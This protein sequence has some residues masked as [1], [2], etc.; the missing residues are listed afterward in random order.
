[1]KKLFL[2]FV[3]ILLSCNYK[4]E[5]LI[6]QNETLNIIK[7]LIEE[8]GLQMVK[9]YPNK[10]ELPICLNLK[11]IIVNNKC[12]VETKQ[13]EKVIVV[14][15]PKI[16]FTNNG[17]V[18][19]EKIYKSTSIEN[20]FFLKKD[21]VDIMN[22]NETFKTFKIPKSITEKFKSLE[23]TKNLKSTERYIQ[24]SIPIFSFDNR[25]AYIEFDHYTNNENSYGYS[26]YLEK[27][28]GKWKIKYIDRNWAT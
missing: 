27:I 15:L 24:F 21:S 2:L 9:D 28:K 5:S 3:F 1:M 11:K 12:F 26:I 20:K 18:C 6:R 14:K 23:E 16:S 19:I 22:Q 25:K 13:D 8:K 4:K 10:N 7:T 17:E